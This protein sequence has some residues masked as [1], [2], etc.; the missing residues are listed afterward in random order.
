GGAPI[1]YYEVKEERKGTTQRC[2]TN[3]CVF[4]RLVKHNSGNYYF[5]VRAYNRVGPSEYSDLSKTARA[6]TEPGRVQDIRMQAQADGQITIAWDKPS[7]GG[8]RIIDYTIS[9][10]GGQDTVPGN[11][12]SYTATGLNN[13]EKYVFT[14]KAQN[15]VGYSAPRSSAEFQPLGT[16][17]APAAPVV[18]DL[19]AGTNQTS[20]RIAWQ[21]V[22]PEGQGP[23]VYTVSYSNGETSGAVAGC[24]KLAS[25]TCTHTGVPYDGLAYTYRVV[26]ANQ[27]GN[28]SQPSEGTAIEAVG[29][30]AQ[31]GTFSAAPTGTSQE[32]QLQYT[33]PDS[34]GSTSKVEIL[35]GGLVN[36]TFNQQTGTVTTRIQVPSNDQPY[37][38]QL[39]VC[40]EKAPAGC[41]LSGQQN[42]QSYGRLDG[43]LA[44]IGAA[45]V[46]GKSVTW[47]VNGSSNGDAA[48]LH[49]RI[50]GG[51]E[52]VLDL[53]ETGA[54]TRAISTTTADF[55]QDTRLEVWLRDSSPGGRGEAY[56]SSNATSGVPV[57][58]VSF[59]RLEERFCTDGD[60]DSGNNCYDDKGGPNGNPACDKQGCRFISFA[61]SSFYRDFTCSVRMTWTGYSGWQSYSFKA[62]G[63]GQATQDTGWYAPNGGGATITCTSGGL[64]PQTNSAGQPW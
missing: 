29:R 64:F 56:R 61:V 19:E 17:P 27:P 49:Y 53:T 14:V 5:R 33:V 12:L 35:V 60:N 8:T 40:N 4:R 48:Q 23:T 36:R 37:P 26:A 21:A 52:Q 63:A 34:R 45:Q 24:Q 30:P 16:P 32:V 47:S 31:W 18:S 57:P 15:D 9:W 6:D 58:G 22:L 41:T 28:R 39:R 3:E 25:L 51:A 2:E 10:V 43:M 11:K 59:T 50:D 13:N 1:L 55:A 44:E 38:V 46:N 42:V 62:T 54:F 7:I 20:M